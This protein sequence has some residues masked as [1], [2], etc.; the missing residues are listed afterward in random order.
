MAKAVNPCLRALIEAAGFPSHERFAEAVNHRA[1][2]RHGVKLGY[3][4]TSVKRWLHGATCHYPDI[5]AEVLS[6]AWGIPIP[7]GVIW[8]ELR[9]GAGPVPAHLQAWVPARTL[10]DIA[11]FVRSDM[12]TRRE[13]L[14]DAVGLVAGSALVDPLT[15][16]I[17]AGPFGVQAA[18]GAGRIGLST[19]AGL[20]R[21]ARQFALSDAQAGGGIIREAAVGQLKY[22]VDLMKHATYDTATG[23]RL[24]A[25]IADLANQV[26]WMSYD[27]GMLGPAQ[28]YFIY[29]LQTANESGTDR[30]R[31]L[32]GGTLTNMSR[33]MVSAGRP[34]TAVRLIDL[35]IDQLPA[36]RNRYSVIRAGRWALKARLLAGMGA[37]HAP[38]ARAAMT[39]AFELQSTAADEDPDPDGEEC[40]PY[41]YSGDAELISEAADCYRALATH[42]PR[43]GATAATHSLRAL[44][45]RD[46]SFTRSLVFD[47][48]G[49]AQ[50]RILQ[51]EPE[52]ACVDGRAALHL[53]HQVSS[54][55]VTSRLR[56]LHG[57]LAPYA[58]HPDVRDFR[59]EL[60]QTLTP[61]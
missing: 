6:A 13:A 3:D 49:L 25:A 37:S 35:A 51:R 53:A 27:V 31:L 52:Q 14:A 30:G 18:A 58:I 32:A 57:D 45:A 55:R 38:E 42:E 24:L 8:P 19:S 61:A 54:R 23:Q 16:W 59:D 5:V 12:L 29:A 48:I 9:N 41:L 36:D 50:T 10:E 7:V 17:T 2:V 28:R 20:E 44:A 60:H 33:Q 40:F 39:L 21:A 34:D 1:W 26:G 15:R 22:A 47:H 43:H 4:R 11:V 56:D 46:P